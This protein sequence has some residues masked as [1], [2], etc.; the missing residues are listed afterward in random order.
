MLRSNPIKIQIKYMNII[1]LFC[2][3][4]SDLTSPVGIWMRFYVWGWLSP[5]FVSW[6]YV[7]IGNYNFLK[8]FD[9]HLI[10]TKLQKLKK[11]K[12]LKD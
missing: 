1:L 8:P 7:K 11:G 5:Q 4:R 9:R 3:I 10:E 12:S 6:L 2:C